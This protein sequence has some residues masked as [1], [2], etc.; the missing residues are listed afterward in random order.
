MVSSGPGDFLASAR[1]FSGAEP[2]PR[3]QWRFRADGRGFQADEDW[4]RLVEAELAKSRRRLRGSRVIVEAE[5]P[6]AGVRSMFTD[7]LP[8]EGQ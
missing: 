7:L 2:P 6:S 8:V 4:D 3:P 5:P 1:V